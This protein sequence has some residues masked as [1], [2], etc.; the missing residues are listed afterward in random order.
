[1][2]NTR[3]KVPGAGLVSG[4][5]VVGGLILAPTMAG[6]RQG[7]HMH[8][9]ADEMHGEEGEGHSHEMAMIHG[10]HVIMT[11]QNHFEVLFSEEGLRVYVYDGQ[12]AAIADPAKAS[13]TATLSTKAGKPT[14]LEL[15]YRG[16]DKDHGR[17]QGFLFAP[18]DFGE[19]E[20]GSM[21]ATISLKGIGKD[22][23]SFKI[24]VAP[25]EQAMYACPMNDSKPA[26]DPGSCPK[27]GM[28]MQMMEGMHGGSKDHEGHHGG[29]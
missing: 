13:G 27:C 12:Q 29:R 17:T 7:G 25:G 15:T 4:L 16:P 1:M 23:V 3:T 14:T 20:E 19:V 28:N 2:R 26:E 22:P 5:L 21:K 8:N 11:Q 18:Y 9:G 6:A 10:G 24:A